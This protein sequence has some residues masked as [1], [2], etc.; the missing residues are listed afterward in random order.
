MTT[1]IIYEDRSNP[2]VI[3]LTKNNTTL[4][5]QEMTNLTKFEIRYQDTYYDSADFPLAFVRDD[6]K[7]Q[8]EIK[9]F[10]LGLAASTKKGD[11]VEFIVYD[12]DDHVAG[13]LWSQFTLIVKN[14]AALIK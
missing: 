9:P 13:L 5:E 2:F 10:T 11:L 1:T 4:T 12:N 6:I 3:T 7:G 14:D 8:V